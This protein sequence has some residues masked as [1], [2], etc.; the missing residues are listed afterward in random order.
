MCR[1]AYRIFTWG[2]SRYILYRTYLERTKIFYFLF[3]WGEF[4]GASTLYE[5]LHVVY[6]G[7]Y[8]YY[9]DL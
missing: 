3:F 6:L 1:V 4:W 7:W 8:P 5:T 9:Q 2:N